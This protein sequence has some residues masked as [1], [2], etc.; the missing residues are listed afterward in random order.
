MASSDT[1][2]KP[3][4]SGNPSGRQKNE[5]D[6]RKL[7]RG[8]GAACI[9]KLAEMAGLVEGVAPAHNE[10]VRA[11]CLR[12]LLDRGFGKVVQAIVG[13]SESPLTIK[14]QW[15]SALDAASLPDGKVVDA[16]ADAPAWPTEVTW[17][18]N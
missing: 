15:Q 17:R 13:D 7:A 14:F 12:E 6:V 2:F 16:D 10:G 8:Y 1:W 4:Q 9:L 11:L 5:V 18:A 3:G